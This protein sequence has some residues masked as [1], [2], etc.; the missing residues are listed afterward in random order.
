[1]IYSKEYV[2]KISKVYFRGN[3]YG[4]WHAIIKE[5]GFQSLFAIAG[6][7]VCGTP[8]YQQVY[9]AATKLAL[10]RSIFSPLYNSK[11]NL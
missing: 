4:N 6:D 9:Y 5:K 8:Y 11:S 1:M 3:P 7:T 10:P 2:Y